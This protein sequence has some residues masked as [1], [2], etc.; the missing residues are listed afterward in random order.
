MDEDRQ[1]NLL[2]MIVKN[3]L[4]NPNLCIR[5]RIYTFNNETCLLSDRG[6]NLNQS[7]DFDKEMVWE[8]NLS[9]KSF[10]R[11]IF[12][13]DDLENLIPDNPN[14]LWKEILDFYKS[15]PKSISYESKNN[16]LRE[17]EQYN[18]N[19]VT[20]CHERVFNSQSNCYGVEVIKS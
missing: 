13:R 12:I 8:F 6:F 20:Y 4:E 7:N 19:T 3:I 5:I 11:Y 2:E 1:L 9:S 14:I 18:Q 16:D 15:Q 10:I 17:L